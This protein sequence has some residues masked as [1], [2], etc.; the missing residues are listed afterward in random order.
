MDA[1][2]LKMAPLDQS[3]SVLSIGNRQYSFDG[4]N[5]SAHGCHN[6]G[7]MDGVVEQSL[8]DLFADDEESFD[9]FGDRSMAGS[10]T[11]LLAEDDDSRRV[12]RATSSLKSVKSVFSWQGS[13]ES[14][15]GAG[16]ELLNLSGSANDLFPSNS[17]LALDKQ[18]SQKRTKARRSDSKAH[19]VPKSKQSMKTKE[20]SRK[21][22]L[23]LPPKSHKHQ[24]SLND[25]QTKDIAQAC[26]TD[27]STKTLADYVDISTQN[28][29][30]NTDKTTNSPGKAPRRPVRGLEMIKEVSL[31]DSEKINAFSSSTKKLLPSKEDCS[32]DEVIIFNLSPKKPHRRAESSTFGGPVTLPNFQNASPCLTNRSMSMRSFKEDDIPRRPRRCSSPFRD[33]ATIQKSPCDSNLIPNEIHPTSQASNKSRSRKEGSPS[34]PQRKPSD[35]GKTI[36]DSNFQALVHGPSNGKPHV[37]DPPCS[38][39]KR[40]MKIALRDM[41]F[42]LMSPKMDGCRSPKSPTISPRICKKLMESSC[43]SLKNGDGKLLKLLLVSGNKEAPTHLS[44]IRVVR[45]L[46]HTPIH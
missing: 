27:I 38:P 25:L 4:L 13:C 29:A 45:P 31:E 5:S 30:H 3:M 2:T 8:S 20:K 34:M 36:L 18:H 23:I 32:D 44:S 37:G 24:N 21:K 12:T 16:D 6:G 35:D 9:I 19:S 11:A 40:V 14:F 22:D 28:Q 10:I 7:G 42:Q 1:Y 15:N 26:N 43:K 46:A 17:D 33:N 41:E 39:R